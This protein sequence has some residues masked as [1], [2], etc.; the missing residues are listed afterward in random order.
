MKALLKLPNIWHKENP[1]FSN[2]Y[3]EVYELKLVSWV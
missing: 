3:S 2:T 1:D